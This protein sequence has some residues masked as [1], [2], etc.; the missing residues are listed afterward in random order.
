M[1]A[2][3]IQHTIGFTRDAEFDFLYPFWVGYIWHTY[4][5][6]TD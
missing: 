3:I 5:M 2:Y 1:K 6:L 4:A